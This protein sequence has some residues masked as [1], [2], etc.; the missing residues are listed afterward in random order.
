MR[1]YRNLFLEGQLLTDDEI[2][3]TLD[4]LDRDVIKKHYNEA[5]AA[6]F[7]TCEVQSQESNPINTY[8]NEFSV[9]ENTEKA[10]CNNI[11][12]ETEKQA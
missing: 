2:L 4:E 11:L 10:E 3:E 8:A 1:N 9:V 12:K 6:I 7:A 5:Q